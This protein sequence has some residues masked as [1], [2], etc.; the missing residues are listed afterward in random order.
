MIIFNFDVLASPAESITLRQPDPN[1]R[2]I[3]TMLFEKYMG[4]I[5][6]VSMN[7]Y[8]SIGFEDWLKR[9]QFKAS[10]YEFIDEVDAVLKA[11]RIHRIGAA[12]GR[13]EWYVDND[14]S[15]CAETLKLGIPTL[16]P[17]SPY[18]IRPEWENGRKLK[19]W[20]TLVD[21]MN[22]QALKASNK[23][24]RDL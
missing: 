14:P 23:A 5:C 21:E 1:G 20:G 19:E 16:I 12:F 3:W 15:I 18:I 11:E 7:E 17:A 6:V 10:K 4:R 24:W 8:P 9:E 13:I 2:A 22:A